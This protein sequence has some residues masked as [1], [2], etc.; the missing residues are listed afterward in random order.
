[1]TTES[2]PLLDQLPIEA[3]ALLRR[4]SLWDYFVGDIGEHCRVLAIAVTM[5]GKPVVPPQE[6]REAWRRY[7]DDMRH[8]DQEAYEDSTVALYRELPARDRRIVDD[9]VRSLSDRQGKS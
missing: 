4:G 1:M 8:A 2:Y 6:S 3:T 7:K 5:P 9:L